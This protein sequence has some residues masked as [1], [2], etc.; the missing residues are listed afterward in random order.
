MKKLV[1]AISLTIEVTG[2]HAETAK[3][4]TYTPAP[5]TVISVK[6]EHKANQAAKAKHAKLNV[7]KAKPA[8]A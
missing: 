2:A 7:E 4:A 3:L 6:K 8:A 5:V 1:L